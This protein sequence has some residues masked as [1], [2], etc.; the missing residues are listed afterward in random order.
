M[1]RGDDAA[2][3]PSLFRSMEIALEELASRWRDQ[4]VD[5]SER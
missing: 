2:A 4:R 3:G 5:D 1:S